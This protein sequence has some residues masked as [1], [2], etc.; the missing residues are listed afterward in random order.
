MPLRSP[1]PLPPPPLPPPPPSVGPRVAEDFLLPSKDTAQVNNDSEL[2][3]KIKDQRSV[4]LE[5]VEVE[6]PRASQCPPGQRLLR[7]AGGRDQ[8]TMSVD[9]LRAEGLSLR[10][11]EDWVA[12]ERRRQAQEAA[13]MK[14]LEADAKAQINRT[15]QRWC[16]GSD[17]HCFS[18]AMVSLVSNNKVAADLRRNALQVVRHVADSG[19]GKASNSAPL[20]FHAS[21]LIH[22]Y[23]AIMNATTNTSD[24]TTSTNSNMTASS[25]R[26]A[27]NGA[28][29]KLTGGT[30]GST[31]GGNSGGSGSVSVKDTGNANGAASVSNGSSATSVSSTSS[32][33]AGGSGGAAA[34][35]RMETNFYVLATAC[36]LLAN[37]S[38]RARVGSARPR[39]REELL[40]AAYRV[41]FRGRAVEKGTILS[42]IHI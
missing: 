41:Q 16:I 21:V 40:R 38:L 33:V 18:K 35:F 15:R 10:P 17:W 7:V 24:T 4:H 11:L 1:P 13:E 9:M 39:R 37:K 25:D 42:L 2:V 29:N 14:D 32:T 34:R 28:S 27:T 3:R 31:S 20:V 12:A 22:R 30:T 6:D 26:A 8:V 19:A 5:L 36:L 23:L